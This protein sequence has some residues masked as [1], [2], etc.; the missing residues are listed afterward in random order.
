MF[1]S[2]PYPHPYLYHPPKKLQFDLGVGLGLGVPCPLMFTG[3]VEATAP[4]LQLTAAVLIVQKPTQFDDLKIGSSVAINGCCLTVVAMDDASLR[5]D[6]TD[7]T[8][9]KATFPHL[10][11]GDWVNLERAMVAGGRLDGHIVQGHVEGTGTV[12]E[13]SPGILRVRIQKEF[14]KNVVMKGSIAIDGVSLTIASIDDD[15]IGFAI[16]PHTWEQT[17]MHRYQP[18]DEVNVETDVLT[19]IAR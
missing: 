2:Q 9:Q 4:I 10:Q 5:F 11:A 1:F 8:L 6:L 16:I 17:I 12:V 15:V 13:A 7:E 18:G 3:I 14:M 19:R